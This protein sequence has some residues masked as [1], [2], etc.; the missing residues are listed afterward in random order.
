MSTYVF[1]C[2]PISLSSPQSYAAMM[3]TSIR[4]FWYSFSAGNRT[5]IV[6]W[7]PLNRRDGSRCSPGASPPGLTTT[8]QLRGDLVAFGDP[9]RLRSDEDPELRGRYEA[10]SVRVAVPATCRCTNALP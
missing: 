5:E 4:S 2:H 1:P 7:S 8:L 9:A 3:R 10:D 6:K